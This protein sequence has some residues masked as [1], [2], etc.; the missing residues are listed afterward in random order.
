MTFLLSWEISAENRDAALARFNETGGL[1]P[2][3]VTMVSRWHEAGGRAGFAVAE[4]DSAEA[5]AAWTMQW[6]D[7][8]TFR[9][10][11]VVNDAQFAAI[12]AQS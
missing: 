3:G 4:S 1:P 8:L 12:A 7:L 11:P 5:I 10:T 9:V 2:E 6:S